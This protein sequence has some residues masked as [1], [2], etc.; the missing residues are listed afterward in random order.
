ME[1]LNSVLI[2]GTVVNVD[3]RWSD[4]RVTFRISNRRRGMDSRFEVTVRGKQA[5]RAREIM[6]V[7]HEVRAVG[8]IESDVTRFGMGFVDMVYIMAEH[9][10]YGR[11]KQDREG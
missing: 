9:V 6:E 8:K 5:E 10:E 2:E 11:L 1:Q 3:K 4:D 7:G